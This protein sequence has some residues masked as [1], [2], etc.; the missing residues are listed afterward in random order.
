MPITLIRSPYIY[1]AIVAGMM[2][3]STTSAS[4]EVQARQ[5]HLPTSAGEMEAAETFESLAQARAMTWIGFVHT[6]MANSRPMTDWE[7]KAT[8]EAFLADFA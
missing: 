2:S 7:R 6:A 4:I 1:C 5:E 8:A 3:C